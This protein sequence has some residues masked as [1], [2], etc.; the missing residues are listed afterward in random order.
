MKFEEFGRSMVEMLGV[1]SIIGVLSIGAIAG[2]SKAMNKYKLNQFSEGAS[3]LLANALQL[4][5][6]LPTGKTSTYE[7]HT[8]LL[9]KL[10]L[11]PDG[12]RIDE[13]DNHYI[14]DMF[15][16]VSYLFTRSGFGY[17][18][19]LRYQL[20]NNASSFEQCQIL[21][22]VGKE[23]SSELI[24]MYREDDSVEGGYVYQSIWGDKDC[25]I[26]KKPC[27]K[28][29]TLDDV[30]NRCIH[31]KQSNLTFSASFWW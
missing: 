14:R 29:L 30:Y 7:Y 6:Q 20:P 15:G 9:Y 10:N 13:N 27:L 19:I 4:S 25:E 11:L 31:T 23:F 5:K 8:E 26:K 21:Y 12:F 16:N 24:K 28:D 3:F 17:S 18:W 1:L 2:Y 22:R